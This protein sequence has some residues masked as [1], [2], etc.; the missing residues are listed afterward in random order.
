MK[1]MQKITVFFLTLLLSAAVSGLPAND[2]GDWPTQEALARCASP[3]GL[4][5]TR[6]SL[7]AD[8][9][10]GAF[11]LASAESGNGEL[12]LFRINDDLEIRHEL[13]GVT[14]WRARAAAGTVVRPGLR[15]RAYHLMVDTPD[16]RQHL[17]FAIADDG[18]GQ[19]VWSSPA[20]SAVT[21]CRPGNLSLSAAI[22]LPNTVNAALGNTLDPGRLAGWQFR[23]GVFA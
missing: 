2:A 14:L 5:L 23:Q 16:G 19:L 13:D 10:G 11:G 15:G 1:I 12:L 9:S 21:E 22:S 4:D 20:Y 17:L 3:A 7:S 18:I 8:S 6:G